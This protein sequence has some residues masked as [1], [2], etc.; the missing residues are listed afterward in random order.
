[1]AAGESVLLGF[2]PEHVVRLTG[3]TRKQLTDWDKTDFFKPRYAFRDH[4]S[5]NSRVYSFRDVVG[6]RVISVLK[7]KHGISLQHLRKV[8]EKLKSS[9]YAFWAS[10]NVF[11]V[12][13]EVVSI[14]IDTGKPKAVVS[15]QYVLECIPL[16]SV[17]SE[18]KTEAEKLTKRPQSTI[19]RLER[20]KYI[21]QGALTVAG[22]R[23]R[24]SAIRNFADAGYSEEQILSEYPDLQLADIRAVLTEAE[25]AA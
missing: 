9:D 1:M 15:G 22:T 4:R 14:E 18:M 7:N 8:A 17:I 19:G 6:L 13:R 12:N 21:S 2:G 24:A 16:E 10:L 23:I 3:L 25:K 20:H 11:V 5:P